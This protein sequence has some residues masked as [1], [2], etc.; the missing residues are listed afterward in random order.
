MKGFSSMF[1]FHVFLLIF[2]HLDMF[3]LPPLGEY[4]S[5]IKPL[6]PHDALKHYFASLKNDLISWNLLVLKRKFSR[7]CF[8]NNSTFF[9]LS[10]TSSHFHPLQVENCNSNSRLVVD[11]NYNGNFFFNLNLLLA[12]F[13]SSW[14]ILPGP[15]IDKLSYLPIIPWVMFL[16]IMFI[17]VPPVHALYL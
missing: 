8:K 12:L 3:H 14:L 6:N 1:N 16:V 10:S 5:P 9:H 4:M 13:S 17:I 7:N 11:E 2:P 15:W